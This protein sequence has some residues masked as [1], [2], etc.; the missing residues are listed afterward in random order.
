[1]KTQTN[2]YVRFLMGIAGILLILGFS[3]CAKKMNFQTSNVVP[4]ARG[5]A[6]IK[7]DNNNNYHLEIS[8]T[9]LAEPKRLSPPKA[10]YVVWVE[11]ENGI[12]NAGRMGSSSSMLSKTLKGSLNTVILNKPKRV[13]ITAEDNDTVTF[14]GSEVILSTQ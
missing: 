1:M 13:F 11:T 14:P 2:N 7:K 8:V 4:A 10:T 12:V 3:S 5:Y 6:K 9:N